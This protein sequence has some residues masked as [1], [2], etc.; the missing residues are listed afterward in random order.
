MNITQVSKDC[1]FLAVHVD[2]TSFAS[3]RQHRE[4]IEQINSLAESTGKK[5][6][7]LDNGIKLEQLA[8]DDLRAAGLVRADFIDLA[9]ANGGYIKGNPH[10]IQCHGF[11]NGY[12]AY[13]P[14][15]ESNV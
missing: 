11:I 12:P 7:V 10:G 14:K 4:F 15:E 6:I 13:S 2:T 5:V 9:F 1:E 8:D 3:S